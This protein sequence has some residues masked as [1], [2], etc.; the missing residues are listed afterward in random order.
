MQRSL[1]FRQRQILRLQKFLHQS[2]KQ[3]RLPQGRSIQLPRQIFLHLQSQK[4]L[5]LLQK[6]SGRASPA[7]S[8]PR[9]NV[10]KVRAA[11]KVSPAVGRASPVASSPRVNA[12]KVRAAG[13]DSPAVGRVSLAASSPRENA[14]RVMVRVAGKA[15]PVVSSHAENGRARVA[16]LSR[17]QKDRA[18]SGLVRRVRVVS[19]LGAKVPKC[20]RR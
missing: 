20:H 14:Q 8:S 13:K 4:S 9:E 18:V 2:L 3:L 7:A 15:S 16:A 1:L 6:G 11:G 17:V 10:P 19:D 5:L 12:P